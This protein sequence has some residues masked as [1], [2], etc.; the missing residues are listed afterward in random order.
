MSDISM[1][2]HHSIVAAIPIPAALIGS[3]HRIVQINKAFETVVGE[4]HVGR[5][6]VTSMRQPAVIE[7]IE[8]AME[9]QNSS[10]ATYHGRDGSRDTIYDVFANR[11]D[12]GILLTLIDRTEAKA[13]GQMRSDFIAN[14]SHE[15]RTPL[16]AITGF[17][18]TLQGAARDDKA[19]QTRFL[20]IMAQEAGRMTRL[21][22]ELM[23]LSRLEGAERIR[24][25]D[26]VNLKV[27]VQAAHESLMLL[28][29]TAKVSLVVKYPATAVQVT[30]DAAQLQ[31]V[32]TNLIEN[33]L[34]YAS[35]S[36]EIEVNLGAIADQ[37]TLRARGAILTVR[38]YGEGIA[39]HH[40]PRLTERFYRVD[41]HRSRAVGG[42]G[43]GLAIVKHIVNRHRGRLKIESEAG[44][45]TTVSVILPA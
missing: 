14:V 26:D 34:K 32:V 33:A 3:D 41:S 44:Q 23:S 16:T 2:K 22:D 19:A 10:P 40:I 28:A 38:D 12:Q 17:I 4:D 42:T 6:F 43:L 21:V 11:M 15:L 9:G 37:P 39:S 20:G 29:Q 31:Q 18:E 1:A 36:G 35:H 5:H 7:A 24:P 13:A 45:G 25:T 27:V 8:Q 30:G